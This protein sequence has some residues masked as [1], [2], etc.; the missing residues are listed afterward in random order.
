[1]SSEIV[2]GKMISSQ[3]IK[4]KSTLNL[5]FILFKLLIKNVVESTYNKISIFSYICQEKFLD[6]FNFTKR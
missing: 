1:M 3:G 6:Y 4:I 5:L 2:F